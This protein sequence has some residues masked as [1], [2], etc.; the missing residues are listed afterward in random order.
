LK[1]N[2][3]TV[4][5]SFFYSAPSAIAKENNFKLSKTMQ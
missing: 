1:N 5:K 3:S 2:L 4:V